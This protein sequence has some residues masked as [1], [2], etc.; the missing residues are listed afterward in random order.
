MIL[1][2][3]FHSIH[4]PGSS[5]CLLLHVLHILQDPFN[6]CLTSLQWSCG[7]ALPLCCCQLF[8]VWPLEFRMPHVQVCKLLFF[9][10]LFFS[11]KGKNV[12]WVFP[13]GKYLGFI[14]ASPCFNGNQCSKSLFYFRKNSNV[15][16]QFFSL[17]LTP[18][19]NKL[20]NNF[21]EQEFQT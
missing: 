9:T 7:N 1:C 17:G 3:T 11:H 20:S 6:L 14:L 12:L 19:V 18:A 21:M 8:F 2:G 4:S 16:T 10:D 5:I 13:M 15:S